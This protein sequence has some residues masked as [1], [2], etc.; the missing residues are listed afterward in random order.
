MDP[1]FKCYPAMQSANCS[2]FCLRLRLVV[3]LPVSICWSHVTETE[4]TLDTMCVWCLPPHDVIRVNCWRRSIRRNCAKM[5]VLRY[6]NLFYIWML[7]TTFRWGWI[8]LSWQ[9]GATA[10]LTV[11]IDPLLRLNFDFT[12]RRKRCIRCIWI[13]QSNRD[14]GTSRLFGQRLS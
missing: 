12:S 11:A 3:P 4:E 7:L 9:T 10:G 6:W 13:S 1:I 5:P 2:I 14:L 8:D